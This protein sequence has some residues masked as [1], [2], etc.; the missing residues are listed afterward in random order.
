MLEPSARTFG[1]ADLGVAM[2]P[3]PFLGFVAIDNRGSRLYGD[4]TLSGGGT[5][6][7]LLGQN[8]R[9]DGLVSFSPEAAELA[10]GQLI[11][12]MP[13]PALLGT[14][15]DGARFEALGEI[16]RSDPDLERSG[17]EG[18]SAVGRETHL[19]AGLI[20]PFVRSRSENLFGRLNL[21]WREAGTAPASSAWTWPTAPTGW[22]CW[23]AA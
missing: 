9:I 10:F 1:A 8:E 15:L 19:R 7:N 20:V 14:R 2:T 18:L 21:G 17:A 12:D 11:L 6:Y 16:S 23:R 22:W 3:D 4:W 13:I 5:S